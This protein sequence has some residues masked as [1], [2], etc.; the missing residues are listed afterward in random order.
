MVRIVICDDH[1]IVRKGLKHLID[2]ESDMEIV[3]EV[4]NV[5]ELFE[6]LKY[7]EVD[8][9]VLD[10]SMPGLTGFDAMYRINLYFPEL[11]VLMLSA[12][13]EEIY[14]FKSLRAGASGFLNK[15][16]A[17]EEL[18]KAIRKIDS[19]RTYMS[20][21]VADKMAL[22]YK[23]NRRQLPHERLSNREFQVLRL[24]GNG[25]T[26][27]DIADMLSLSIKTI[28]TYKCRLLHKL[29]LK[30]SAE[31]IHYCINESIVE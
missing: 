25:E 19:G 14:A 26:A 16:S 29:E 12:L 22:D 4:S 28:S 18:V 11:K 2:D 23:V 1:P 10:I 17:P 20:S 9:L 3:G 6:L 27:A 5:T 7:N 15:E 21:V 30:R 24:I 8:Q 13:S 31:L